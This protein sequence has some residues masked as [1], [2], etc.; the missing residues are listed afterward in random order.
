LS[1]NNEGKTVFLGGDFLNY[2]H[3]LAEIWH[4][5]STRHSKNKFLLPFCW[6][7]SICW[8]KWLFLVPKM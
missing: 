3:D 2:P 1:I 4:T 8:S 7:N 5:A 6:Q